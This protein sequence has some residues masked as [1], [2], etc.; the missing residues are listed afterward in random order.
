MS[1]QNINI[2]QQ[3][4]TG[5]CDLKCA[6][7]FKYQVSNSTVKNNGSFISLTY[8]NGSTPPVLF[9]NKKYNVSTINIVNPSIHFFNNNQVPAELYIEHTP[10]IGG[11]MLLVCVPITSSSSSS[12]ATNL[13]T[14]IIQRVSSNAPSSGDTTS[15]NVSNFS[16]ENI[17]PKKPFYNY[18]DSNNNN[19]VVFDISNAIT[20]SESVL[21]TLKKMIKPFTMNTQ[22]DQLFYNSS[23][24]NASGSSTDLGDGIYISCQ[25]TDSSQEETTVSFQQNDTNYNLN[26]LF[27]L[28]NPYTMVIINILIGI[29]FCIIIYFCLNYGYHK[30]TDNT[31]TGIPI[32]NIGKG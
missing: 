32:L 22:S 12:P 10:I 6:Y 1:N 4:K 14:Q 11:P 20:L 29:S 31:V 24:P 16:L 13:L 28:N 2:S 23:G 21:S 15:L 7:K 25:P 26:S 27:D 9:N 3:N 8:D 5:T 19:W 17:I 18:S 30:F